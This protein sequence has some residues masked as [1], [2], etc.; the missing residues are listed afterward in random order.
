[1]LILKGGAAAVFLY[2]RIHDDNLCTIQKTKNKNYLFAIF[3]SLIN[4]CGHQLQQ[5]YY[6]SKLS[7]EIER[8]AQIVLFPLFLIK[9]LFYLVVNKLRFRSQ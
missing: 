4:N 9:Y 5:M 2:K 3:N 1:M 8:V 6:L 7:S